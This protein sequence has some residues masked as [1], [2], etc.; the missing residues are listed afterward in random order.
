MT[1]P[2]TDSLT[3]NMTDPATGHRP[4]LTVNMTTGDRQQINRGTGEVTA[5]MTANMTTRRVDM[6]TG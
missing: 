2:V 5:T 4:C 1:G 6:T 3:V